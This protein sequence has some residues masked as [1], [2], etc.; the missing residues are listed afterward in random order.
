MEL[1]KMSIYGIGEGPYPSISVGFLSVIG[2][3]SDKTSMGYT[4]NQDSLDIKDEKY[5]NVDKQSYFGV[6]DG[7]GSYSDRCS[8][9]LAH[10]LANNIS[11]RPEF[12]N[13]VEDAMK[14]AY[15]K[16][17]HE[18]GDYT[19]TAMRGSTAISVIIRGRHLY[20]ANSGDC[21]AVIGTSVG[22]RMTAKPCSIDH[23][24][25]L[26]G[27]KA[28]IERSGGRVEP[29]KDSSG[30]IGPDRLW[31]KDQMIPGLAISRCLGDSV[32]TTVGLIAT[33][34]TQH[35]KLNSQDKFIIIASDG[36]WNVMNSEACV[37]AIARDY[38]KPKAAATKLQQMSEEIW[39]RE[40]GSVDD[41]TII[42][43]KLGW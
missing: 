10:K 19:N 37:E 27:E 12:G 39:L 41:T 23:R 3:S 20:C 4:E 21:R 5:D 25:S 8:A 22:G 43:V 11:A 33:P 14:R 16:T 35:H 34:D 9:F 28:R 15:E 18:M 26:P 30:F 42:V 2:R 29:I 13:N 40:I 7:H 24:P 38:L 36:L 17:N 31:M 32:A 6:Y 1:N